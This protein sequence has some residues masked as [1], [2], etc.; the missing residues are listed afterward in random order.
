MIKF[1]DLQ[2]EVIPLEKD[3]K[4]KINEICF[5]KMNFILGNE[6]EEFE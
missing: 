6:I 4:E 5:N 2:K 1:L 3:L